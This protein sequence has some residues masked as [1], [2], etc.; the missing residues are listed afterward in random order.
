MLY[1]DRLA[2]RLGP[3]PQR[4]T[5]YNRP[6]IK[7]RAHGLG[8]LGLSLFFL[9]AC[10]WLAL[11]RY[12]RDHKNAFERFLLDHHCVATRHLTDPVGRR[13]TEY[14]CADRSDDVNLYDMPKGPDER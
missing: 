6:V 3:I 9:W 14:H 2:V 5:G 1:G 8:F 13:Y 11:A 12:G 4:R 10:A 7:I